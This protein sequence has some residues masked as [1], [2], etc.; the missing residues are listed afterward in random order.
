MTPY[1]E[2]YPHQADMGVRGYGADIAQAFEQTAVAMT[3]IMLDPV[4]INP[5]T[6]ISITCQAPDDEMLLVDWLNALVFEMAT[7]SMIFRRFEVTIENHALRARAWGELLDFARHAPA[8]EIKGATF[9]DLGVRPVSGGWR[10]Q[11][12]VD[13]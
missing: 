9:T 4:T 3:A 10:A 11:C 1:W 7:R 6:A 13:V 8:V 12:V 2:H 5:T